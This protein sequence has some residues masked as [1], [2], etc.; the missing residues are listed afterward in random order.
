MIIQLDRYRSSDNG[1]AGETIESR[2]RFGNTAPKLNLRE[3]HYE[4]QCN[5]TLQLPLNFD[6]FNA[7]AFIVTTYEL[8]TQ[9]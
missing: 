3:T 7:R 6:D 1:S 5:A 4:A 9:I 8:A 2:R